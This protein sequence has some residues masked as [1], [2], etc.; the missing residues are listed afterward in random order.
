MRVFVCAV[1]WQRNARPIVCIKLIYINLTCKCCCF[2]LTNSVTQQWTAR[3]LSYLTLEMNIHLT[4][5]C[6]SCELTPLCVKLE[7]GRCK[8]NKLFGSPLGG[9]DFCLSG[10]WSSQA[11]LSQRRGRISVS[12]H[13]T[14]I[15]QPDRAGEEPIQERSLDFTNI[16]E[17][18]NNTR[19][20]RAASLHR[21]PPSQRW[22]HRLLDAGVCFCCVWQLSTVVML[23]CR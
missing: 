2:N 1:I 8:E 14:S 13:L 15:F 16:S 11:R 17:I 10:V 7:T 12:G 5:S 23:P 22:W 20:Q 21:Q 9:R 3:L 19:R 18:L 6:K 4:L